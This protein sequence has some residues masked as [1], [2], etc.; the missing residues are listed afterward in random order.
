MT[1]KQRGFT[2]I[3]LLL[4]M[5]FISFMLL[6]ATN[7]VIQV[8]RLYTKGMAVRQ[9]NQVGHQVLDDIAAVSRYATPTY[10]SAQ[11]R[12]CVGGTTY[13]WNVEGEAVVNTYSVP[14]ASTQLRFVATQDP[15][16]ELCLAPFGA[17]SRSATKDLVGSEVTVMKLAATQSS[18]KQLLDLALVLST[19][20][21]NIALSGQ[22]TPTTFACDPQ[23]QFC[24]F[25]DFETTVYS[26]TGGN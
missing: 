17:I 19:S 4:A 21:S 10:V 24:A 25:G 26:R 9:I 14:D 8:T 1:N 16:G 2:L 18:N 12:L 13:A 11:N 22:A 15:I 7:T 5:A 20:G 3:E 23:N 6:F